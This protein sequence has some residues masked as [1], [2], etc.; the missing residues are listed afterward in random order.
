MQ[1][2]GGSMYLNDVPLPPRPQRPMRRLVVGIAVCVAIIG[3]C[4]MLDWIGQ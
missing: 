1:D 2:H 3:Y 4:A